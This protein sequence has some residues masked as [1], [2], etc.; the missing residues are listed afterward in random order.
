M[1]FQRIIIIIIIS[2]L[3]LKTIN[4]RSLIIS[5]TILIPLITSEVA[6]SLTESEINKIAGEIT[7][8]IDGQNRG[9]SGVIVEKQGNTYYVLTNWH[10]VNKV[11]DYQVRTPD[12]EMHPVY[13]SLIKQVPNVDLAVVPFTSS[14]NYPVAETGD[15]AQL[16]PGKAV[17]VGGWPR[18]G[19]N[20]Q[21]RI[22]LSTPGVVK[23]RQQPIGGYSLLYDNLVRAGM[24]GGPVLDTEGRLVAINGIVKLQE[25]SDAIVSG[26]IEINTFW[27]W[28]QQVSLPTI[29]QQPQ[30]AKATTPTEVTN[31]VS[32]NISK[33]ENGTETAVNF[34]LA[35]AI[36]H[37]VGGIVNSVVAL[38][39]YIISGSSNGMISVRDINNGEIIATW[40][41]H[42][43]SINSVAVSPN[44]E[45]VVSGSDDKT[46]KIWK[47]PKNKNVTDITLVQTLTGHDDVVD[48]VA[49]A[50]NGEML[51]SGSWD[52]TIKIWNL[53]SGELIR[54]LEGHSEIVNAIAISPDGQFL[55]SGS[56]DNQ[57]KLWNL[58]T[59]QLIRNINT[60][61][62]SILSVVFSPDS[63]ILASSSSDGTIN[64]W[65]LQTD[66]LIHSLKEHID[67]VWSIVITPN[68]K[69]LISSSWDKTIK[70]WELSTGNLKGSLNGHTSYIS[71]VAISPDGQT[72]VSGGWDRKINIWKVP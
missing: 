46:I 37:E 25:N 38:N 27:Q 10:V 4:I 18:S 21:Q 32:T 17:F 44:E 22:F 13:Y 54:T 68:G 26:G 65:N 29:S 34:T 40:K 58:Q 41:A 50:P 35:K 14:Q 71:T 64:I 5:I 61:S 39:S 33:Q 70:F 52:R 30:T 59:G 36:S 69:T 56:K 57:I 60:N 42:A 28:R 12:G 31:P 7:V 51:V 55:A 16:V 11:G 66:E 49:I 43:E 24:S 63:Q 19:S 6:L 15:L 47:L 20:L 67:G 8:R 45:L 72:I 1:N 3:P 53:S 48:A 62:L 9:G 23:G 2:I